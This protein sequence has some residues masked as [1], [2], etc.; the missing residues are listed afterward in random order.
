MYDQTQNFNNG[1]GMG[2]QGYPQQ[3][4]GVYNNNPQETASPFKMKNTLTPEQMNMLRQ[5]K[6]RFN[7]GLTDR[8]HLIAICN[9]HDENGN[10]ATNPIND[11]NGSFICS[12]CGQTFDILDGK[13][14]DTKAIVKPVIDLLQSIKFVN[15]SIPPEAASEFFNIIPLIGK[16]PKLSDISFAELLHK[17]GPFGYSNNNGNNGINML[18]QLQSMFGNGGMMGMSGMGYQSG[19][20]VGYQGQ[21]YP[22]GMGM[23][24]GSYQNTMG[25]M[26]NP[27]QPVGNP[28]GAVGGQQPYTAQTTGWAYTPQPA[29]TTQPNGGVQPTA[30]VA[31]TAPATTPEVKKDVTI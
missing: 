21:G 13:N 17:I 31:P 10:D 16:I 1:M 14:I 19:P 12:I 28:F 4:W 9:H 22:S 23:P 24:Q 25:Q 20:Q 29:P 2:F 26:P 11:E 6:E 15:S 7:L 3:N 5:N 8:D 18:N 30:P 27:Q